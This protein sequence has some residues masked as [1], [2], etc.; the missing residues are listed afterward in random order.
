MT[1]NDAWLKVLEQRVEELKD[2]EE[3]HRKHISV[4]IDEFREW[5]SESDESSIYYDAEYK[6]Q[7][8]TEARETYKSVWAAFKQAE[9]ELNNYKNMMGF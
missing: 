6:A 5:V 9:A 1:N 2:K 4:I 8:I 3:R 7:R